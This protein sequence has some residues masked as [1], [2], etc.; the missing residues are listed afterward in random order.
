MPA[1]QP[2]AIVSMAGVFPGAGDTHALWDRIVG[3]QQVFAPVPPGRWPIAPEAM[4]DPAGGPD[5]AFHDRCGL[6]RDFAPDLS[7]LD[8]A[9]AANLDPVCHLALHAGRQAAGA[10]R[11]ER[12]NPAKVAV[13]LAAIALPTESTSRFCWQVF[14][15]AIQHHLIGTQPDTGPADA[16]G[17][18]VVGLPAALVAQVLGFGGGSFTI[19]AACA[20][21]L[22]AVKLA[23]D[24]LAS[25]RADAVLAG[26]VSRPDCLYTQVGFTQL[27]ALSPSGRCAP[28][29]RN[30]DGLMVGEGAAVFVLKRLDD[31]LTHGDDILG[32]IAGIGLSNDIGGG[33]LAPHSEG[34]V[35]A[36]TQ[37][38][39]T[40]G[41]RPDQVDLIEC[42]GAGTPVGDAVEIESLKTLW[43]EIDAKAGACPI[44]SVK[45]NIGHLLTAAGAAGLAK[46]LL[47][48]A[49]QTLAPEAGF[50]DPIKALENSPF[51]VC[52]APVPWPR[53]RRGEPMRAGLSAFGFGGI[54]AH[55]LLQSHEPDSFAIAVPAPPPEPVAIVGVG[56]AFGPAAD[57]ASLVQAL[58]HQRRLV[59]PL[60][61]QRWRGLIPDVPA[62]GAWIEE[63]AIDAAALRIPPSELPD[64]MAQQLLMLKVALEAMADAGLTERASRPWMGTVVGIDFDF[65]ATDF[66]L[67]WLAGQQAGNNAVA[68][69]CSPEKIQAVKDRCSPPL[70]ATRVLGALGSIAASRLARQFGLG[71]PSFTLSDGPAGGLRALETAVRLIRQGQAKA[72]LVGAVD[73]AGDIRA[74]LSH[75]P[76][77]PAADAFPA[78]E[79]AAALVLKSLTEARN[80]GNRIYGV[81]KGLGSAGGPA[82]TACGPSLAEALDEAALGIESIKKTI[83]CGNWPQTTLPGW[84]LGTAPTV[85]PLVGRCGAAVG[86]AAVVGALVQADPQAT[87]L[88]ALVNPQGT[89][90][91]LVIQPG[92]DPLVAEIGHTAMAR[93]YRRPTARPLVPPTPVAP[94]QTSM[95]PIALSGSGAGGRES[96][97]IGHPYP[98]CDPDTDSDAGRRSALPD[99]TGLLAEIM[100]TAQATAQAHDA[101]LDLSADLT[102]QYAATLTRRIEILQ[103]VGAPVTAPIG[104]APTAPATVEPPVQFIKPKNDK[105]VFNRLDCIEFAIGSAAKVLGPEFADVDT[106]PVRVR[107]PDEPLMLVDRITAISGT[108]GV[109]GPGTIVT[110]HD[111]RKG[112]WYLDGDRAPVCIAV[113]AGQADLFLSAYLGIDKIVK[114]TRAYRL[115]D[116]T[117]QFHRGLPRPGE[118]IRYAIAI[119]K[120]VRQGDTHMFFFN[121]KGTIDGRPLITMQGGCAGF[122]TAEEVKNSGGIILT[123]Q[124]RQPA[125]GKVTADYAPLLPD[126]PPRALDETAVDALARG[127]LEA[128]FGPLFKDLTL[129]AGLRLP[130]GRMALIH[131]VLEL[132]PHG[133]RFG[134][135]LIR[136]EA[137]IH[138]DDWFLTCHF[139][140]DRVMP[141]TLMYQC[142]EHTLRIFLYS[143]G[144]IGDDST[145]CFEPVVGVQ[146]RLKCR[147]PVTPDT[148]RVLYEVQVKEIGYGPEPYAVADAHMYA[149]GHHIVFFENLSLKITGLTRQRIEA[150]WQSRG[151][152]TRPPWMPARPGPAPLFDRSRLLDFALGSPSR[153]FGDAYRPFDKDRFIARLPAPP[154]SFLDWVQSAEAPAWVM[155]PNGWIE[156]VYPVP[157]DAWYFRADRSGAMPFCVLLEVSLQA[158][159]WLASWVGSALQSKNELHFRNLGGTATVYRTVL[160]G[161]ADL[162]TR[163]RLTKVAEAGDM[164]IQHYDFI[165]TCA[166]ETV[167]EGR[168]HFGFFTAQALARQ[169]GLQPEPGAWSPSPAELARGPAVPL[170]ITRPLMPED[171]GCDFATG[172]AMPAKCLAMLDA[173]EVLLPEGGPHGLGYGRAMKTVDPDEWFF[174]AHFF[175]DPVCPGSLGL[176]SFLQLLRFMAMQ[177]WPGACERTRVQSRIGATHEWAYRGQ[178]LRTNSRIT[179]EAV[180]TAAGEGPRPFLVADGRLGVDGMWIYRMKDFAIELIT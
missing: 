47:A 62:T 89:T 100:A 55:L 26:G 1:A 19:D 149:D 77:G 95:N 78:G 128:C 136:G 41:W 132:D 44:G 120:F 74:V 115:L 168:T 102:R 15:P 121:F 144:W 109:P 65:E 68:G 34:Q 92:P 50:A 80:D 40:A 96:A 108:K 54:N 154:Y 164:I 114:G 91:H 124:D 165:T 73:M 97:S 112:A 125:A 35:R 143:I 116:A 2:I 88:T 76:A 56:A 86:L 127:D 75:N 153:A 119:D 133:G 8:P 22:Y 5:K 158:C 150:L 169:K 141:G 146:S 4:L 79:G 18:G 103:A 148:A 71:G 105:V 171:P 106:Y 178:I 166:G 137:D 32:V 49:H 155:A 64:L 59:G 131:R 12:V 98:D 11:L 140:D 58:V 70:N 179:V 46:V 87:C 27:K 16:A 145:L 129:P 66:H 83:G 126:Q 159:G 113:E 160:P 33:L 142:C 111:V 173:I 156:A 101:F 161:S 29:D 167:Y 53:R 174:K 60:P 84:P 151:L 9:L 180:V 25:G 99:A 123:D 39:R 17:T 94:A 170:A 38:Y 28:F 172:V 37:A 45:S 14:G 163:T 69:H 42:H 107:L 7:G 51:A 67:R 30:A 90:L 57:M 118:T 43:R 175:Q 177:R 31:A 52:T 63:I 134:L 81:I 61:D 85:E 3:R 23:C 6:I 21:S 139:V 110:E 117:V 157:S 135:G 162:V 122:F 10:C 138:P 72:M 82:A 152:P 104:P 36:M 93:P 48:F 147:G 13:I 20:S 176:E 24:R 130:R